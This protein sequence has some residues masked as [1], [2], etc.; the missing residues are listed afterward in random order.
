MSNSPFRP[1]FGGKGVDPIDQKHQHTDASSIL[2]K[3]QPPQPR[4]RAAKP[5]QAK[6]QALRLPQTNP[7][8]TGVKQKAAKSLG[9]LALFV[10]KRKTLIIIVL[11]ILLILAVAVIAV[12]QEKQRKKLSMMRRRLRRLA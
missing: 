3:P 10:D 12:R 2:N 8:L 1:L 7:Q 9:E 5:Q 4:S 11:I 6:P